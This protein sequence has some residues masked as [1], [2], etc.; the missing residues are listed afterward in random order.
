MA[1]GGMIR[2]N[3]ICQLIFRENKNSVH[4]QHVRQ[5]QNE[6]RTQN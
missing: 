6:L 1:G 5:L 2:E 4:E 3:R